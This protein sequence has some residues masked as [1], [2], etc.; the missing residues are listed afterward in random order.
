[1]LLL[2]DLKVT[3]RATTIILLYDT[4]IQAFCLPSLKERLES[5]LS[6]HEFSMRGFR[7]WETKERRQFT[8]N[9][10]IGFVY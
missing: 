5:S 4:P 6:W 1:M 3:L 10:N 8:D 7:R 9:Q 2:L